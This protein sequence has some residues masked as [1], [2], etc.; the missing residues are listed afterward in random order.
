MIDVASLTFPSHP[1]LLYIY[2]L[3]SA[4]VSIINGTTLSFDV[5]MG[6]ILRQ[7]QVQV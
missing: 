4:T 1:I 2:L 7:Y 5:E 3:F 6:H